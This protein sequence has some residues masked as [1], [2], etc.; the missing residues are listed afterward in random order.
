MIRFTQLSESNIQICAQIFDSLLDVP[1][2]VTVCA[3]SSEE[4][5]C[6]GVDEDED[7]ETGL[8][9]VLSTEGLNYLMYRAESP[10]SVQ[11]D[12]STPTEDR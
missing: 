3:V 12:S 8:S 6:T 7:L 9:P 11:T 4:E 10:D 2:I 5:V 1:L